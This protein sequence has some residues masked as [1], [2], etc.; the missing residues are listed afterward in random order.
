LRVFLFDLILILF[1]CILLI[2][3]N[4]NTNAMKYNYFCPACGSVLNVNNNIVLAV[5]RENNETGLIF[6]DTVLGNY[7]KVKNSSLKISE[8]EIVK[9][10]CPVCHKDLL[11]LP[12][13]N[14]ARLM[15]KDTDGEKLTVLF[16]VKYGEEST[17]LV[18]DKKIEKTFGKHTQRINFEMLSL[19]T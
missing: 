2:A 9:L 6:L 5:Q 7:T 16:S 12:D 15:M 3:V 11:C 19:C 14:L 13:K 17:Y 4:K 8:G 18:K 1:F 10:F